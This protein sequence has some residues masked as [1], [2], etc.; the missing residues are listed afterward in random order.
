MIEKSQLIKLNQ[1]SGLVKV[2][3]LKEEKDDY[4]VKMN[5]V[6][7]RSSKY[8]IQK[9]DVKLKKPNNMLHKKS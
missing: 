6:G 3:L 5:E 9:S 8:L 7:K 1:T 2:V 4:V